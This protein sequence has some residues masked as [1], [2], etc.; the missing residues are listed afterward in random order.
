MFLRQVLNMWGETFEGFWADV[1]S[2]HL[3][4]PCWWKLKTV[5]NS[6]T[7]NWMLRVQLFRCE[8]PEMFCELPNVTW[9][10]SAQ[11]EEMM[12]EF[13]IFGWTLPLT[14]AS[15]MCHGVPDRPISSLNVDG[16]LFLMFSDTRGSCAVMFMLFDQKQNHE[17]CFRSTAGVRCAD[18]S[19]GCRRRG[20][21]RFEDDSERFLTLWR[22]VAFWGA[23]QQNQITLSL[24]FC[25]PWQDNR[26]AEGVRVQCPLSSNWCFVRPHLASLEH[27]RARRPEQIQHGIWARVCRSV[28]GCSTQKSVTCSDNVFWLHFTKRY[29]YMSS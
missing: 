23:A 25:F 10:S 6:W 8:A 7:L 18:T 2:H 13:D 29:K 4:P 19:A 22:R 28:P 27:L 26:A 14:S 21:R 12:T 16:S 20:R 24:F 11:R 5:K 17:K 1:W 3:L 15:K 9:P